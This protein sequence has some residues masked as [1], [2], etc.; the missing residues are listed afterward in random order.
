MGTA[1]AYKRPE[2]VLVVVHTGTAV[3][4]LRRADHADFWQSVTGSLDWNETPRAA[5][6]RELFE[7]TGIRT[8]PEMLRDMELVHR[9]PIQPRWRA[10]Y[11]PDVSENTEHTF[12][13]MLPLEVPVR[14]CAEH[15]E[16]A[17]FGVADAAARVASWTN[18]DAIL[19]IERR[20]P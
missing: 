5:A 18:R 2:S 15:A 4:L 8:E 7:E 6:A 10:R 9:Y 16:Y 20:R 11:A 12:A 3:L 1:A 13:L 19:A 17:W 14:L